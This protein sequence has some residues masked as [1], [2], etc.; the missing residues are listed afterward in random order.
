[1]AC[2]IVIIGEPG[3]GKTS[4]VSAFT[5]PNF[6]PNAPAP[7]TIGT[8][9]EVKVVK[10][11]DGQETKIVCFDT[12]MCPHVLLFVLLVLCFMSCV[13]CLVFYVLCFMSYVLCLMFYV[14]CFMSYVLYF[15]F[16][17]LCFIF[18]FLLLCIY[19]F[20]HL[21]FYAFMFLCLCPFTPSV[22]F[23]YLFGLTVESRF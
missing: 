14:L 17:I 11:I 13:L 6:D 23:P 16:C 2:R 12:G 22:L 5:D 7:E 15:L 4:L 19:P 10:T 3:V 20:T 8:D 18:V 1:M 21:P 9:G